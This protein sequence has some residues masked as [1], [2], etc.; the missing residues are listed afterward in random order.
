MRGWQGPLISATAGFAGRRDDP[1]KGQCL[2]RE[3][4]L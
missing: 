3:G 4:R 1:G 2:L